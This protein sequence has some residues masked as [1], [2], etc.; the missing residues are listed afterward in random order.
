MVLV[1][2]VL[3]ACEPGVSFTEAQPVNE[4]ALKKFPRRIRGEYADSAQVHFITISKHS[5]VNNTVW[6]YKIDPSELDSSEAV[7]EGNY[8]IDLAT[9]KQIPFL[10]RND[11]LV[12]TFHETD[13]IFSISERHVLKKYKGHYFI[14]TTEN[15]QTWEVRKLTLKKGKLQLQSIA[16]ETDLT[17]LRTITQTENDTT[18]T[19]SPTKKQFKTFLH[20]GGFNSSTTYY[21]LK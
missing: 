17:K 4:K 6:N 16:N 15:D 19:F 13:T 18:Y 8:I 3:F 1:V 5:V 7:I 20:S 9:K 21:K 14:N 10:K 12:F 2:G 11:S